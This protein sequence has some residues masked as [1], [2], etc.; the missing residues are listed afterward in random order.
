MDIINTHLAKKKLKVKNLD[1]KF[2]FLTTVWKGEIVMGFFDVVAH[3]ITQIN[4]FRTLE[5]EEIEQ[6]E[7]IIADYLAGKKSNLDLTN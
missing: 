1:C 2:V 7:I 5:F 6:L 3:R 4:C